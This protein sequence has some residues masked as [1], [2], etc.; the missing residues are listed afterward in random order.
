M[1]PYYLLLGIPMLLSLFKYGDNKKKFNKKFPM[2]VFFIILIV[3]LSLRSDLC[4]VDLQT[5]RYK[6]NAQGFVS[7]KSLFDISEIEPGYSL[8][9]NINK[10]LV[11]DFQFL[12]FSC[13][14]ISLVPVMALYL[15]E[16]N[17][18]ILTIALFVGVAPFTMFF[19]GLKQSIAMGLGIICYYFCKNNK[20][21]PFLLFVYI[22]YMFH[23]SAV[24]LLLMYPLTHVKITK[25]WIP[26]TIALYLTCLFYNKQIF[27]V[28]LKLN[29][30]YE[31]DYVISETGSYV[32]LVLLL[33]FTIFS[34][35]VMKEDSNELIGLRNLLILSLFIQCFA[36]INTVAMRLN[37]YY[38]LFIPVLIPKIIDN[39]K[40]RYKQI[41]RFVEVI[42]ILFFIFWFFNE[43]YTGTNYL[44]TFPYVAFWE[45]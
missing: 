21:L 17:H 32:F 33:L 25:K 1:I 8:F 39:C 20:I 41:V 3:M 27:G 45:G 10:F 44:R 12:L 31:A 4:G 19:S 29:K 14:I 18:S 38:L 23:Q 15:K 43:A 28:L 42:F 5:Y 30:N 16:S 26:P 24:I 34:V 40:D 13:A 36:P 37:Y 35:V 9:V 11:G 7:I 6:Y 2:L 22:A